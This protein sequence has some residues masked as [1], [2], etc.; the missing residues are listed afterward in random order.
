VVLGRMG[1]ASR[2]TLGESLLVLYQ[3]RHQEAKGIIILMIEPD[4][5]FLFA[6]TSHT[7]SPFSSFLHQALFVLGS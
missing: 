3:S 4:P 5:L 1:G 6:G 2:R 7:V